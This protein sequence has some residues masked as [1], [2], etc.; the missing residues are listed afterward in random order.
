MKIGKST[1]TSVS[2]IYNEV[3]MGISFKSSDLVE[4][5]IETLDGIKWRYKIIVLMQRLIF[6]VYP[7]RITLK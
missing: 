3:I 4:T 7:G 1:P 2:L 5:F 6:K